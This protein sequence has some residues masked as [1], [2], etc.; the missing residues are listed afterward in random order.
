METMLIYFK[1]GSV[2]IVTSYRVASTRKD[3]NC[4]FVHIHRL[5]AVKTSLSELFLR[6]LHRVLRSSKSIAIYFK[7]ISFRFWRNH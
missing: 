3:R 1:W 2:S 6:T 4:H 7:N 5:V